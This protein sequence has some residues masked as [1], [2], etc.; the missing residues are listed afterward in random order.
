[1]EWRAE[2]DCSRQRLHATLYLLGKADREARADGL[3]PDVHSRDALTRLPTAKANDFDSL[4]PHLW[5]PRVD[6]G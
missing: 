6:S 1:M 3:N 5:Q 2:S 4:L